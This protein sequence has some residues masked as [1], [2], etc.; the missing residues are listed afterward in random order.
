MPLIFL[1]DIVDTRHALSSIHLHMDK[2]VVGIII[3]VESFRGTH[4]QVALRITE[5]ENNNIAANGGWVVFVK[6]IIGKGI[7]IVFVQSVFRTYPNITLLVLTDVR[8]L[9]T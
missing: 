6:Q 2:L 1:D 5:K 4:P 7:A 8:N 3:Q 9:I